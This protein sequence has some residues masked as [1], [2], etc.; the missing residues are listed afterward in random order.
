MNEESVNQKKRKLNYRKKE[1]IKFALLASGIVSIGIVFLVFALMIIPFGD[2]PFFE[3]MN[4]EIQTAVNFLLATIGLTMIFYPVGYFLK[5]IMLR[6][7]NE[8]WSY[9]NDTTFLI[10]RIKAKPLFKKTLP[11]ISY[12]F[13]EKRIAIAEL[14]DIGT[15]RTIEF[16]IEVRDSA[17]FKG[18]H[19][20]A[21]KM[22][23]S[24]ADEYGFVNTENFIQEITKDSITKIPEDEVEKLKNPYFSLWDKFLQTYPI[25]YTKIIIVLNV[26]LIILAILI[27]GL[28]FWGIIRYL[29]LGLAGISLFILLIIC[30]ILIINYKRIKKYSE[31]G[32]YKK[33]LH[34]LEKKP[35]SDKSFIWMYKK[36]FAMVAA[37][38]L[39]IEEAIKPISHIM[40]SNPIPFMSNR[41]LDALNVLAI[42][43]GYNDYSIL[44]KKNDSFSKDFIKIKIREAIQENRLQN[45]A[46]SK[47][48]I[49]DQ[50]CAICKLPI[51]KGQFIVQCKN[52]LAL[53]HLKHLEEWLEEKNNCPVCG[54]LLLL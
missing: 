45:F 44:L 35:L 24:F 17:S 16:I 50:V 38:T 22:I 51:Q 19:K 36:L 52:C 8:N 26:L 11:F 27:G 31:Q 49:Q 37:A 39:E 7:A 30:S 41:A 20:F 48:K 21:T 5:W 6:A 33:I 43:L 54:K 4:L 1:V 42:N 53:F 25:R 15:K 14:R 9:N 46:T 10:D 23:Q 13:W 28:I 34:I 2:I 3:Q 32:N 18:H 47:S 12:A 40:L 29:F